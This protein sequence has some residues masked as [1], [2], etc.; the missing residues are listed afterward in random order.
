MPEFF[1]QRGYFVYVPSAIECRSFGDSSGSPSADL[2]AS[3]C[4][5][6]SHGLGKLFHPGNP[7]QYDPPS[8]TDP[9]HVTDGSGDIPRLPSGPSGIAQT[10]LRPTPPEDLA[11]VGCL[12]GEH[13]GSYCE[14]NGTAGPDDA[15][16]D[17][18]VTSLRMLANYSKVSRHPFW[19]GV[20]IHKPHIP[21]TI[22]TRFF[23]PLGS[24]EDTALPLH[25]RPPVGMP[26]I[27][28]NKGL[29]THALDSYADANL[30]PLHS[31]E[32]GSWVAFPHNLT[33]AMRRGYYAAVS[34]TDFLVGRVLDAL[35]DT[36][37]GDQTVVAIMGDHGYNLGVGYCC[38][39]HPPGTRQPAG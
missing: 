25:E 27:A 3:T 22:P 37:L 34:Y 29:G 14:L 24:I 6:R 16:I 38:L 35:E 23:K 15:L 32:N 39:G 7:P 10:Q 13:G 4:C 17:N 18:A 8:W 31:F 21:W 2:A 28:W 5:V 30:H 19:L 1:K 20:G 36:G 33:K 12:T 9:S 11:P 26:P